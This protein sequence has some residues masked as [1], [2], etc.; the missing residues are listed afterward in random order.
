MFE[1]RFT[2]QSY[3][4]N[5]SV[6]VWRASVALL[7]AIFINLS[8]TGFAA[9]ASGRI[10]GTVKDPWGASISAARVALRDAVGTVVYQAVSNSEGHFSIQA[11]AGNYTLTVEANG[12]SQTSKASIEVAANET[13]TTEVQLGVSAISEQF[14]VTATRTATSSDEIAGSITVIGS[15]DFR[16]K[17]QAQISEPLRLVPGLAVLQTGGR[18]GLTTIFTRGGESDYNKVL[19]DGVPVNAAG[20]LFD[21]STLTPENLERV[22]VARG[23]QSALFGSDAMTSVIQLFTKRGATDTPELELSGEGG[24]FDFHRET[25]IFSGF[26]QWFDYAASYGFQHTDGRFRNSDYTNRSASINFG[27]RLNPKADLRLTSR[28][29]NSTLGVPGATARIF[30]DPSQRQKHH[31]FSLAGSFNHR[32]TARWH[33]TARFIFAEFESH[34]FDTAAEDLSKANTPLLAP[35]AFGNDFAFSFIEHQKRGGFHYQSIAALSSANVLTAGL[36]FEHES[37]VFT[38]DFSRVSPDRNNLGLY[39]QDQISWRQ[40]LFITAGIRIERNSG[41]TPDDLQAALKSLGSTAPIGDVGFGLK[42]NPKFSAAYFA[43]RHQDGTFGATKLKANF[44]TGIKEPSLTEAFSPS[45]FFLG[46]P[47]LKPERA[48]SYDLGFSQ[49]LFNRRASLEATYFDNRF[50]NQII[51]VFD[52]ATFG[53][54]KLADGKLTNFIN[55]ERASARGLEIAAATQLAL[56]LRLAASYTVLRSRLE[57]AD[58]SSAEVGLQLLRRPRHS[59][60]FEIGWVDNKFDV[61]FDGSLTGKRRDIDPV[62]GARFNASQQPIFSDGYAK[63][64][65]A[66]SYHFTH[67]VTAFARLENLLNQDYQEILGYPAYRL[68]FRAGLRLRIGGGN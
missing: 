59:G 43:R 1:K 19:I 10:E 68:N 4:R 16:R 17:N 60:S 29:N 24:S 47:G 61:A 26:T 32:T 42:V 33:Q 3:R 51:F 48:I 15:D 58:S 27:F 40:R 55:L 50:R 62:S 28:L 30:S 49:E 5:P 63:L 2:Y 45:T 34:S 53:P 36:D 38:D 67:R 44:G 25:A 31:D 65:A 12:F 56:K 23:P 39:V 52:P 14:V 7:L 57:R 64:N 66:G 9:S 11:E 41:K 54:V 20:G 21:F 35:G 37:A 18:G 46:N 6:S 13:K 22:E 8:S